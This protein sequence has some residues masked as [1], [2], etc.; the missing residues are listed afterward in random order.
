MAIDFSLMF[1]KEVINRLDCT[2]EPSSAPKDEEKELNFIK[3]LRK[4]LY[5]SS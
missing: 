1:L 4:L 2:K 3:E 5:S